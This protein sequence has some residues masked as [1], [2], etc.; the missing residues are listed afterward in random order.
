MVGEITE[1][2]RSDEGDYN[3]LLTAAVDFN[4]IEEVMVILNTDST[5]EQTTP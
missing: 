5:Q 4:H 1:V 2:A 3:A